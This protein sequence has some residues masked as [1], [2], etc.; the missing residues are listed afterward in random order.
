M[1]VFEKHQLKI[2]KDTVKH[3]LKAQFLGGM[4][5]KEAKEVIIKLTKKG[6]YY[7]K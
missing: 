5:V 7:G 2:A 6:V 4:T 1:T 3:P